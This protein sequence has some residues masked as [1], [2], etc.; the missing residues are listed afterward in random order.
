MADELRRCGATL[1]AID[2]GAGVELVDRRR[3]MIPAGAPICE[4]GWVRRGIEVRIGPGDH[5]RL[6]AVIG[7]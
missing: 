7:S 5:E 2:R 1:R 6:E 4:S 3:R